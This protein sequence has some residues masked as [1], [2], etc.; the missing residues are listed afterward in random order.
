MISVISQLLNGSADNHIL[1]FFWQHGEDEATL[2]GYMHVIHESGI[3]AVCVESRPHPDYCGEKWWRDMDIILDEAKKRDMK[4]WI[5]DDSHFPTGYANGA[6][7]DA[8]EALCR[9]GICYEGKT[10]KGGE[11]PVSVDVSRFLKKKNEKFS[12]FGTFAQWGVKKRVF[13]GDELLSVTALRVDVPGEELDLT[14]FVK[15]GVLTWQAPEGTWC[16]GLCKLSRNCGAHRN[17]INMMDPDSCRILIDSVYEPHFAHYQDE[18]GKTIAGFFSD[19]PELGNGVIYSNEKLGA[20]QDLPWSYTLEPVLL[21]TLGEDWKNCMPYLWDAD[22]DPDRTA[23]IRFAYMDAV[24]K[25]VAK[26]FSAQIGDWCRA[27]GVQYIGHVVED[28][29]SHGRTGGSLGHYFRGLSGQDMAGIDD[30]GGQV[31]PQGEDGPDTFMRALKRDGE[32]Y[33]Y[34][35]GKLG[36]SH[37]AIDPKKQGRTMCEIFGNYGWSEGL[38]L[39]RFLADHFMVNGVN[40][41]VPHAFSAKAFPDP[42]CPPHFYAHGHNPQYRHFKSL[43]DYMNRVC[44]L[45]SDGTHVAPV[46]LLYH[47]EAEWAGEAMLMQKPARKLL[48]AQIDFDIVPTDVF[49]DRDAYHTDLTKEFRVNTQVYRALVIPACQYISPALTEAIKEL[50]AI[51]VP[52]F[53]VDQL[54]QGYYEGKGFDASQLDGCKVQPLEGLVSALRTA[55]VTELTL[56]PE[57]NRIRVLHYRHE[58]D[59]YYFINEGTEDYH[60]TVTLPQAGPVYAYHAWDNV[61]ERVHWQDTDAGC[62]VTLDLEPYQSCILV[63]D[64]ADSSLLREP[65]QKT[66]AEGKSVPFVGAWTRATCESTAY[67]NFREAKTVSLPDNLAKEQPKFSGLVR[68][69]N[70]VKL[71]KAEKTVL[72]ITDAY[73]GV[74]VFVNGRSAGVQVVPT[75]RFDLTPFVNEGV[76]EIVIEVSTTLE[77]ERAAA[78]NRSMT[79]RLMQPKVLAPT[80]ITGTVQIYQR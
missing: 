8:P 54:P 9:Q 31:M 10:V 49:R 46:A 40:H 68:Y 75:Y 78:K 39:E 25:A 17:Y 45:I 30:I 33:H 6:L 64:E 24:T 11:K 14:S 72:V 67:P 1:P 60:G 4:V 38:R 7:E 12:L 44:T 42:D 55:G 22:L 80:G 59:L 16:I 52:V 27:H 21:E 63:F 48:D 73:E 34:I 57:N 71:E 36:P 65:L 74:E 32:F 15:D 18:F 51:D 23:K 28:N 79:E 58:K 70:R 69:T 20:D 26:A 35:L 3:G 77:R 61:L 37:A 43:M 19:E 29:N 50:Q 13:S 76:N 53:F 62:A 56:T 2:R 66:V 47:A 5:L 41:F